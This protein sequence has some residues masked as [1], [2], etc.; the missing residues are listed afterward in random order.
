MRRRLTIGLGA[1]CVLLALVGVLKQ[2]EIRRLWAVN[3]LFDEGRIVHNFSNMGTLFETV[4][5]PAPAHV[6]SPL[7]SAPAQIA[8]PGAVKD[9]IARRDVTALVVLRKG[10]VVFEDYYLGTGP[11]DQ[12]VSW[13]V[14]KSFLAALLGTVL[15][16]GSIASLDDPVTTYAPELSGSAYDGATIR[17]VLTMTSGVA[18]NED[19]L[20][21][22][23]DINKMG[24]T[25]AL[26][27][28][29]DKFTAG[30]HAQI[31]EPGTEF[32]YVSIDS[33]V[34]G[35]VIRG[36]TGRSI[37][38]LMNERILTPLGLEGAP[39]YLADG[40]GAAFVLGGLN[41]TTRD[42]ARFGQMILQGGEWHGRQIVPADWVA[43]MTSEHAPWRPA[44]P[45]RYG[46]QWWLPT[47]PQPGEVFAEGVYSQYIWIDRSAGVVIA[48]NAADRAFT[49]TGV[50]DEIVAMLRRITEVAQ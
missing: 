23:S 5:M 45:G 37:P 44:M 20:D 12:R 17:D 26:G 8:L 10:E 39:Y 21:F 35:M 50:E 34:L 49:K 11:A 27:G 25:L 9:W 19:Y 14:A 28:S 31:A 18:F 22:W 16:D 2:E 30:Q 48:M 43:Q 32:H 1:A 40:T 13:S 6:P 33:H 38:A 46:Y 42:Y 47:D 3:T 41:L 24:R 36:A 4:P 15:E 29:L 7:P